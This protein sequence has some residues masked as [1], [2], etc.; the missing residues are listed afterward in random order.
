M[1]QLDVLSV[2]VWKKD[3]LR[4]TL[5]QREKMKCLGDYLDSVTR[6]EHGKKK[7][8]VH[9]MWYIVDEDNC[10]DGFHSRDPQPYWFHETE[11]H[12]GIQ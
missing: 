3:N 7:G 8:L 4:I 10:M 5:H 2:I 6:A 9:L 1:G 11:V 12:I